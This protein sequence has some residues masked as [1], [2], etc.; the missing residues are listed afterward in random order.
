M[1]YSVITI[2]REFCTG[3]L[4]MAGEVARWLGGRM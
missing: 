1:K 2:G 4:D 3:G